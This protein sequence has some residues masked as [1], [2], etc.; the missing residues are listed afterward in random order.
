MPE[1]DQISAFL[2]AFC[3][4]RRRREEFDT[5]SSHRFRPNRTVQWPP[6]LHVQEVGARYDNP[7]TN[8]SNPG[9]KNDYLKQRSFTMQ[10]F[11]TILV[12]VAAVP[13]AVYVWP[14]KYA[15]DHLKYGENDFPVRIHRLTGDADQLTPA[16]WRALRPGA[17]QADSIGRPV[18]SPSPIN[19]TPTPALRRPATSPTPRQSER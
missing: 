10:R 3:L 7:E 14:T 18:P 12:L 6:A 2:F 4:S 15:Y 9:A 5:L 11:V 8:V 1:F 16:G 17:S 13:F 19:I